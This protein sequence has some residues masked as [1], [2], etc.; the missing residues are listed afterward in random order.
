MQG[1]SVQIR[2]IAVSSEVIHGYEI[3]IGKANDTV[4]CYTCHIHD[5]NDTIYIDHKWLND[6]LQPAEM[7]ARITITLD[8]DGHTVTKKVGFQV[9]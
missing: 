6:Q 9:Q 3:E 5:H 7:E 1:D 4:T 2:A 8:H